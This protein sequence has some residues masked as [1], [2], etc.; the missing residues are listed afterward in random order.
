MIKNTQFTET[1]KDTLEGFGV[2]P[3]GQSRGELEGFTLTRTV[4]DEGTAKERIS[5]TLTVTTRNQNNIGFSGQFGFP[6]PGR[7]NDYDYGYGA[8]GFIS[9]VPEFLLKEISERTGVN[10]FDVK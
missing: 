7:M 4:M 3:M 8:A 1:W 6:Y 9:D 10:L 5:Y 2:F